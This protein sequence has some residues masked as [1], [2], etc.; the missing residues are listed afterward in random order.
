MLDETFSVIF[1]HRVVPEVYPLCSVRKINKSLKNQQIFRDEKK[2]LPSLGFEPG[3]SQLLLYVVGFESQL[4]KPFFF[5]HVQKIVN[6]SFCLVYRKVPQGYHKLYFIFLFCFDA[7]LTGVWLWYGQSR[8]LIPSMTQRILR[9]T[10]NEPRHLS[11]MLH[12]TEHKLIFW[13][14]CMLT[15]KSL[16]Q[17]YSVSQQDLYWYLCILQNSLGHPVSHCLKI[18][19]NVAF[20]FWHFPPIFVLLKLTCLVTLFDRKLRVFKNSPKW[21]SFGIFN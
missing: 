3:T 7:V 8:F 18:T 9:P 6:F 12:W 2:M 16:S 20:E 4:R 17:A 10:R 15:S 1:K 19:Q 21:T 11:L 14:G 5:F 13:L